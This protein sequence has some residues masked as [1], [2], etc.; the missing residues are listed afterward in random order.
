MPSE[1]AGVPY[2]QIA[3]AVV[4]DVSMGAQR[5]LDLGVL[6]FQPSEILKL[7]LPMMIAWFL[8]DTALPAPLGF[9][10]L[11]DLAAADAHGLEVADEDD[12]VGAHV[13][14]GP[15]GEHEIGELLEQL[16]GPLHK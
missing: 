16:E 4:G 1:V 3:V 11:G 7:A 8:A 12:R 13:G 15:P 5:W 6:R 9:E 14:G 2:D 10:Q